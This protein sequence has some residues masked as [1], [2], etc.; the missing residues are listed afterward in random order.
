MSTDDG[1]RGGRDAGGGTGSCYRGVRRRKW[2][3]WV[4]EIREPGKKSRIWLGSFETPEMA[5]AAYDVAALQLRGRGARLNF[6]GLV[7]SLPRPVTQD[8]YD[9]RVAAHEAALMV[10]GTALGKGA[11]SAPS[12]GNK[13]SNVVSR[14][15]PVRVMLSPSQIR[16]INEWPLDSPRMMW[17]AQMDGEACGT[18][19]EEPWTGV[20]PELEMQWGGYSLWDP[21]FISP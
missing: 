19:V 17:T 16:A 15:A 4:S 7:R 18:V 10:G 1:A 3:K 21:P 5:A 9:I 6:P 2:G 20:S 11:A 13:D 12:E 8:A 14:S